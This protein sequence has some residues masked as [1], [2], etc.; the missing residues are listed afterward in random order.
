MKLNILKILA[1]LLPIFIGIWGT[2]LVVVIL[3]ETL[4]LLGKIIA[5]TIS[6]L[7]VIAN[8]LAFIFTIKKLKTQNR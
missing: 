7:G 8:T 4:P 6:S 2:G 5:G 3:N 1:V